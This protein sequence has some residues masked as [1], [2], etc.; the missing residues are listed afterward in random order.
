MPVI[1]SSVGSN[2]IPAHT[3]THPVTSLG[4]VVTGSDP[5]CAVFRWPA[6]QPPDAELRVRGDTAVPEVRSAVGN[7]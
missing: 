1:S 7:R 4:V 6:S 3:H 5:S 2:K